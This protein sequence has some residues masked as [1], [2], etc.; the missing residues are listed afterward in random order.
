MT[1]SEFLKKHI[2]SLLQNEVEE[3]KKAYHDALETYQRSFASLTD[4]PDLTETY[5]KILKLAQHNYSVS[6]HIL[7]LWQ[8]QKH[9]LT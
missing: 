5:Y 7:R 6:V 3:K 1:Q 9:Q 8:N 2:M 4:S